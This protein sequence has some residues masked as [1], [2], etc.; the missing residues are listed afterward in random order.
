V[1]RGTGVQ[2]T[3]QAVLAA[4][5]RLLAERRLDEL[6]VVE[7]IQ[8]AGVSRASFYVHFECKQAAVAALAQSVMEEIHDLWHP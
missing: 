6:T 7:L 8:E 3:R 1:V 5:E 2:D 4:A